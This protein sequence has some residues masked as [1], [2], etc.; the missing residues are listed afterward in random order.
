MG[1]DM[2]SSNLMFCLFAIGSGL[3]FYL[4]PDF[5]LH[6]SGWLKAVS[7]QHLDGLFYFIYKSPIVVSVVSMLFLVVELLFFIV[8]R[9]TIVFPVSTSIFLLLCWIIGPALIVNVVFKNHVGRPRPSQIVEFNGSHHYVPP[10]SLSNACKKNCS[11]VCGHSSVGFVFSALAFVYRD[12]RRKILLLSIF[13]GSVVGFVRMIQG[14]H[15]LSD[16]VFSFVFTYLGVYLAY[17]FMRY[18]RCDIRMTKPPSS[19]LDGQI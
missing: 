10:F 14:G 11:F 3:L 6:I 9:R 17:R 12:S 15:F 19:L 7:L 4:Y 16:I 13:S 2:R 18:F 8:C 5:D 1:I